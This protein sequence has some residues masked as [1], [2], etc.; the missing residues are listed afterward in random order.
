MLKLNTKYDLSQKVRAQLSSVS[1]ITHI[2]LHTISQE[3]IVHVSPHVKQKHCRVVVT[4]QCSESNAAI[5]FILTSPTAPGAAVQE[6]Y[7]AALGASI[8]QTGQ[9]N[10][11]GG[12]AMRFIQS[13]Q[14]YKQKITSW[15]HL[16][17]V[18][19]L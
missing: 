11:L 18:V 3:K 2:S 5:P 8:S 4:I 10:Q 1:L 15:A 7:P 17:V 16:S 6:F 12:A 14:Y 13:V 19:T 9:G